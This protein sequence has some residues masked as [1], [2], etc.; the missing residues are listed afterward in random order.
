METNKESKSL[1]LKE[2]LDELLLKK[3]DFTSMFSNLIISG[4]DAETA[5]FKCHFELCVKPKNSTY[6]KR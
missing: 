6:A 2:T 4:M 3:D 1:F 5:I